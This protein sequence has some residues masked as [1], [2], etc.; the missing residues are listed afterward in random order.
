M[1][2][3]MPSPSPS[4]G[5]IRLD[6]NLLIEL[7]RPA[8][9]RLLLQVAFEWSCIAVLVA[10]ALRASMWAVSLPCIVLIATRQHALLAL[11]HE[12]SHHQLSRR[13]K[14][15]NDGIGDVFTALPFFVTVHGFRRNHLPHHAH[16][17]TAQD[18]NWVSSQQKRR[19]AFP[20]TRRGIFADMAGHLAGVYT[21]DDLKGYT[22]RSGMAVG[23]PRAVHLRQ[24]LFLLA[25]AG[26]A[27]ATGGWWALLVYWIVP[28]TTVLMAILYVRDLGEHHGM[29]SRGILASRT[30]QAGWLDRL[31]FCQNGVNFHTEHHLFPSV[32]F[33]RL[34]RLH[35]H[36]RQDPR[37]Q[38][39]AVVTRGYLTGLVDELS[40][41]RPSGPGS[42]CP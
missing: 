19:Y 28:L 4:A 36:L 1:N 38:R 5:A 31:L 12:F 35:R 14:W 39:H 27:T 40:G 20:K 8:P 21:W 2:V 23:L 29:P 13:R 42:V 17:S 41:R 16:V 15:L 34:G 22:V 9:A 18:P 7:A 37:Y 26:L 24:A 25:V 33:F 3:S 32:P 10:V 6:R 30:V 11:M